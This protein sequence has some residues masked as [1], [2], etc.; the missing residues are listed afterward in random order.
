M[1]AG[2]FNPVDRALYLSVRNRVPFLTKANFA[3]PYLGFAQSVGGRALS[4]GLYYPLEDFYMN[5]IPPDAGPWANMLAGTGAGMTNALLLNPITTVKYKTWSRSTM[6][7]TSMYKEA[8]NMYR[9]GG[10]RPFTNGLRPTLCRDVVFGGCYT[11]LRLE[12][13]YYGRLTPEYQFV[14]NMVAAALATVLSGPFNLARNVQY[15]TKSKHLAPSIQDVLYTLAEEVKSQPTSYRKWVHVQN[16]LRIGWGTVRVAIGMA[17]GQWV[18]EEL[19]WLM[20]VREETPSGEVVKMVE[21]PI[22]KYPTR[23]PSLVQYRQTKQLA[24]LRE[25]LEEEGR[26]K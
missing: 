15:A 11:Y 16:R 4:G 10:I 13:Q 9:K 6:V 25:A 19:M 20:A 3:N 5:L 12:L 18:Y 8:R 14:G 2:I 21:K 24:Q 26:K 1:Q 7:R 23:R 17:F 22:V